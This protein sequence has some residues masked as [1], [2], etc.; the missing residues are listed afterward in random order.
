MS[1]A[2]HN[3]LRRKNTGMFTH[4]TRAFVAVAL[5]AFAS[6]STAQTPQFRSSSTING[7]GTLAFPSGSTSSDWLVMY[8]ISTSTQVTPSG[9]T[10]IAARN[11]TTYP[12]YSYVF[13]RQQGAATNVSLS[14]TLGGA[15]MVAYQ[16]AIGIGAVGT[17][18]E[19]TASA[20]AIS[21]N[22]ITPQNPNSRVLGITSDRDDV[23]YP[24]PPVSFTSR[25]NFNTLYFRQNISD[26]AYGSTAATGTTAWSQSTTH[27]AVGILIEMLPATAAP[28]ISTAF[29]PATI[30][31]GNV[32][33]LTF[34]VSNPNAA[35]LTDANFTDMLANMNVA[36]ATIGGTCA[37]VTNSPAL[38]IGTTALNLTIPS[39]PVGGCTVSLQV[40]SA[41]VGTNPNTSSG[42]TTT[43]TPTAGAVSNTA[44]LTVANSPS[45]PLISNAFSPAW[46]AQSATST[47]TFT[48]TSPTS[49]ALTNANFT[50]AL[51]NMT[52]GSA[53][54]GG[55]CAG[56]TNSP[57]LSIGAT[58][59]NL[60][61]PTLPVTGCTIT[62]QVTSA[63]LGSNANATSGVMSVE[64]PTAGSPSNTA[65]L[66]VSPADVGFSY[67]HPD[68]LGTPRAIT[69]PSDNTVVWKWENID[70]FGANLPNENPSGLGVFKNNNRFPG[71]YFD[72]ETG[73][74][75]N[76]NRD[77]DAFTGRFLQSDPIGLK[78]GLSTYGYVSG[79]PLSLID[80][81]GLCQV[82]VWH[83]G[84]IMGWK[85]CGQPAA[86]SPPSS[87]PPSSPVP[88]CDS[89]GSPTP[90]PRPWSP[91]IPLADLG[92]IYVPPTGGPGRV[93]T[94]YY[95]C[96]AKV[97][98]SAGAFEG[99]VH[100]GD[101][102]VQHAA[103]SL[104]SDGGKLVSK[105]LTRGLLCK[106]LGYDI[107]SGVNNC[108]LTC[109]MDRLRE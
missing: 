88:Q 87:P 38:S 97:T 36:S 26:R 90:P 57:A 82:A 68:H 70:P 98:A 52:V 16:S 22:S 11:W 59:L 64:T 63:V 34:N 41:S 67:V 95:T 72:E 1:A 32:S 65:Y 76:I 75:Y 25:A 12:Y 106:A 30:L 17:F 37:G 85:P 29:S 91:D 6:L 108:Y 51:T 18:A 100:Y 13:A 94:C 58:A 62:V 56:V 50:D 2:M 71:Q 53:T 40:T 8:V 9:W 84:Y 48:L 49:V 21:L 45:P 28:A 103:S 39:L 99:V 19:S 78:G 60:T 69:R 74:H 7:A 77:F 54:M 42:V 92:N 24:V 81:Y 47:L 46:I 66:T 23:V 61:V 35:P 102:Q 105:L 20:N 31:T 79:N 14:P 109:G 44:N 3:I 101:H 96:V 104:F 15:V 107:P 33:T 89:C 86:P 43:Q 93:K 10:L 5:L 73:T 27:A 4:F 55:S 80:P 83:G